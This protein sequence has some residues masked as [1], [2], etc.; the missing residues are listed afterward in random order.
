M[1]KI[2]NRAMRRSIGFFDP[3]RMSN[4]KQKQLEHK[5]LNTQESL[6]LKRSL[7]ENKEDEA[8]SAPR[9]DSKV[10]LSTGENINRDLGLPSPRPKS[11][12][13]KPHSSPP[14]ES[15][16]SPTIPPI[17]ASN[18]DHVIPATPPPT[19]TP[20]LPTR[21]ATSQDFDPIRYLSID[22]SFQARTSFL[23]RLVLDVLVFSYTV[24]GTQLLRLPHPPPHRT[25]YGAVCLLN[26]AEQEFA[27]Y[28]A[29][30]VELGVG[31]TEEW[32]DYEEVKG[33]D[34]GKRK[35]IFALASYHMNV[36]QECIVQPCRELGFPV[37]CVFA[38]L[39]DM[40]EHGLEP[41]K[42]YRAFPEVLLD[43]ILHEKHGEGLQYA[44][45]KRI[46]TDISLLEKAA[47]DHNSEMRN[48]V[49]GKIR[50]FGVREF[51]HGWWE[52]LVKE[53][54]FWF[55]MKA[56]KLAGS[57]AA[58]ISDITEGQGQQQKES[59][60]DEW[61]KL[62][63]QGITPDEAEARGKLQMRG[64]DDRGEAKQ[65]PLK[66]RHKKESGSADEIASLEARGDEVVE[67]ETLIDDILRLLH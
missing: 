60:L 51:G 53:R 62:E 55:G 28:L 30:L 64:Q 16:S 57:I 10:N 11:N 12:A 45:A 23:I 3:L 46:V 7:N 66:G 17:P 38:L 63:W 29:C 26:N 2:W 18:A 39:E 37:A 19:P 25:Q 24:P 42:R 44:L 15:S 32:E 34:E 49:A 61:L 40:F 31:T 67:R 50:Q 58:W 43:M 5:V 52:K 65:G 36:L 1:K 9:Y 14:S 20:K 41:V 47:T 21:Q 59:V 8:S 56:N 6:T 27:E 4:E 48:L 35:E 22:T 13:N 33:E 54:G